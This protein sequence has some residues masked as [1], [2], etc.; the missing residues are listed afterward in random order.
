M[1]FDYLNKIETIIS[2]EYGKYVQKKNNELYG[3][4]LTIATVRT[5]DE[6][7]K[8]CL[9]VF[10]SEEIVK[11]MLPCRKNIR[12]QDK[13]N[14]LDNL[15]NMD[16]CRNG[17]CP[18]SSTLCNNMSAETIREVDFLRGY[19]KRTD[20]FNENAIC[21]NRCTTVLEG[22][23]MNNSVN[24]TS[25]S[26][27]ISNDEEERE[28][29]LREISVNAENKMKQELG[30]EYKQNPANTES[31]YNL[32]NSVKI[33]EVFNDIQI[34]NSIQI[35]DVRG[36]GRIS[37]VRMNIVLDVLY[38]AVHNSNV[39]N[40]FLFNLV[41]EMIED[42]KNTVKRETKTEF[43]SAFKEIKR[44]L[45]IMGVFCAASIILIIILTIRKAMKG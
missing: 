30:N 23:T 44:D 32:V 25:S 22:I 37:N 36:A 39:E 9:G 17:L 28:R 33:E 1:S 6:Q 26:E 4:V 20:S 40:N 29:I 10:L 11:D 12:I 2:N 19:D 42:V 18:S 31:I 43:A 16:Y 27:I 41:N 8:Q 15:S 38:N 24:F 5:G 45:I 34:V 21:Y 35:L 14:I 7:C 13:E 3:N